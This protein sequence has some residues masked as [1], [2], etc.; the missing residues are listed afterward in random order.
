[1]AQEGGQQPTGEGTKATLEKYSIP[2]TTSATQSVLDAQLEALDLRG[3]QEGWASLLCLNS[4]SAFADSDFSMP[5]KRKGPN[6]IPGTGSS[7]AS[8]SDHEVSSSDFES[9]SGIENSHAEVHSPE[10]MSVLKS[11]GAR[12]KKGVEPYL[13]V[14]PHD[15]LASCSGA[16]DQSDAG[17]MSCDTSDTRIES[18]IRCL[19]EK[20]SSTYY[21][22]QS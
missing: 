7:I 9:D 17:S 6:S 5:F 14:M 19:D 4:E 1:M 13:E 2:P 8:A 3:V 12:S 15:D 20:V 16:L 18:F 10:L 22:L 21:F 11:L